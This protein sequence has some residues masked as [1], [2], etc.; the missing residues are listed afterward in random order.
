M[1]ELRDVRIRQEGFELSAN[2]SLGKGDRLAL[3][4]PSGA[5]KTTLLSAITGF[6]LLTS[7]RLLF[8]GA[9]ITAALPM[10]RPFSLLFQDNNLFPHMSV[11]ENIG[12]GLRPD[13]RLNAE[14]KTA[15]EQVLERL[16]L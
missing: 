10:D 6:L 15:V 11:A 9:D 13:L 4:G 12:L 14:Q 16:G 2:W 1:L 5:G 3:I 7:G 8:E